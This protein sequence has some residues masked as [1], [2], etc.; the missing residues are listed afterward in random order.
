LSASGPGPKG[1]LVLAQVQVRKE[2]GVKGDAPE[3][4]RVL[5]FEPDALRAL[6]HALREHRQPGV[7]LFLQRLSQLHVTCSPFDALYHIPTPGIPARA[8]LD[9]DPRGGWGRS[10]PGRSSRPPPTSAPRSGRSRPRPRTRR[11]AARPA[12]PAA[13]APVR[14]SGNRGSAPGA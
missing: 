13:G 3:R 1:R 5:A 10:S 6:L 8:S 14:P 4:A 11:A 12:P 2:S 7:V 9:S